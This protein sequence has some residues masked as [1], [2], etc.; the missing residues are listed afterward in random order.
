MY[1]EP[2]G[3]RTDVEG[4][5]LFGAVAVA[6][7]VAVRGVRFGFLTLVQGRLIWVRQRRL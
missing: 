6:V 5:M 7:A 4:L 3:F 2:V 1:D